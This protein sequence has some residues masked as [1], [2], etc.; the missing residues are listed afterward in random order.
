MNSDIRPTNDETTPDDAPLIGDTDEPTGLFLVDLGLIWR[1]YRSDLGG[2]LLACLFVLLILAGT[3]L[4]AR[5]G[6]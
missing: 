5:I 6:A 2:F 4:L 3:M 1:R